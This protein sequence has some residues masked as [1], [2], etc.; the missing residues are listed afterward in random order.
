MNAEILPF[1]R[2]AASVLL[3]ALYDLK[4]S[5]KNLRMDALRFFLDARSARAREVWCGLA[6][7]DPEALIKAVY[8]RMK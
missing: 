1:R 8:R 4:S 7:I 6:G 2:L 3:Q 5:D